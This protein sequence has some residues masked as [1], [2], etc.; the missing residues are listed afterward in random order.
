MSCQ[1]TFDTRIKMKKHTQK[2]HNVEEKP[3]SPARKAAKT[4]ETVVPNNKKQEDLEQ[5]LCAAMQTIKSLEEQNS[6][7]HIKIDHL[8][9]MALI[10]EDLKSENSRLKTY[11][12]CRFEFSTE[13]IFKE[14][15]CNRAVQENKDGENMKTK[16]ENDEMLSVIE[17]QKRNLLLMEEENVKLFNDKIFFK[18]DSEKAFKNMK[19]L[20]LV[21]QLRVQDLNK[22]IQ[23]REQEVQS[24]QFKINELQTSLQRIASLDPQTVAE[25]RQT[26]QVTPSLEVP[27]QVAQ[28]IH[29]QVPQEPASSFWRP[30][31]DNVVDEC[32]QNVR[33][34]GD[35]NHAKY[36]NLPNENLTTN[37]AKGSPEAKNCNTCKEIFI[38]YYKMMDHRKE[39]HPSKK[40]CRNANDCLY[41]DTIPGCWFRHT[42]T[43]P[44]PEVV[45]S[46]DANTPTTLTC[47]VC[48]QTFQNKND[49][50]AHKKTEHQADTCRDFL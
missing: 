33:C 27:P 44:S 15:L 32:I 29:P 14:H 26:V 35:C 30:F 46:T 19:N 22:I 8:G 40:L 4:V 38:N 5:T 11:Q 34:E 2:E 36:Q 43:I 10:V 24:M 12:H 17:N 39:H 28:Y 3:K 50:M 7:L 23:D 20:E 49:L 16:K 21:F 37:E 41:N 25:A 47:K 31:E 45:T 1:S 9:E 48:T 6:D 42:Q 18:E 13:L